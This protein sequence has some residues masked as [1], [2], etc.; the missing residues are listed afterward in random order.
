MPEAETVFLTKDATARRCLERALA[1]PAG[2]AAV[3]MGRPGSGRSLL[4]RLM[5]AASGRAGALVEME[6]AA[7][8]GRAQ[9]ARLRACARAARGGT[10]VLDEVCALEPALQRLLAS[11]PDAQ[12]GKGLRLIF[13]TI[14]DF[15]EIGG[16]GRVVPELHARLRRLALP[17][18]PLAAR[19]GDILPLLKLFS[20]GRAPAFTAGAR[21]ALLAYEW[22]GNAGEL[23]RFLRLAEGIKKPVTAGAVTDL[24]TL[25]FF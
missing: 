8:R 25:R 22:P 13:T 2:M 23:R 15:G 18:P 11:V 19:R 21:K 3:I 5:H 1:A 12:P 14:Y 6:C 9:A 17:I 4:A 7:Y 16:D 20:G 10:L 24:L